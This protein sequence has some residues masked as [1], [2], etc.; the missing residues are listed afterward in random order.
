MGEKFK[1]GD[2]VTNKHNMIVIVTDGI[3]FKPE[4]FKSFYCFCGTVIE[5]GSYHDEVGK[6]SYDWNSYEFKKIKKVDK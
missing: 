6:H 5:K 3:P 1:M 2:L 4:G